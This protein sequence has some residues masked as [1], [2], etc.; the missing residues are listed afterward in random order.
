VTEHKYSPD[1][2]DDADNVPIQMAI[3]GVTI[4]DDATPTQAIAALLA[5]HGE[6]WVLALPNEVWR[7]VAWSKAQRWKQRAQMPDKLA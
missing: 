2:E 6:D 3:N 7:Q 5:R 1:E 4:A